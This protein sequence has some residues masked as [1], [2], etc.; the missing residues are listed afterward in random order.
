[1]AVRNCKPLTKCGNKFKERFKATIHQRFKDFELHKKLTIS[2]VL[3]LRFNKLHF[4]SVLSAST[5]ISR[6]NDYIKK[7]TVQKTIQKVS[8]EPLEKNCLR[9]FHDH[10][11]VTKADHSAHSEDSVLK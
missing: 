9:S 1:M 4:E 8:D 2:N 7:H 6:I 10:L 5:A 3:D 11:I